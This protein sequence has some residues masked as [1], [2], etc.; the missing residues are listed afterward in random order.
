MGSAIFSALLAV[1]ALSNAA[2]H[3]RNNNGEVLL[4]CGPKEGGRSLF[5]LRETEARSTGMCG[6]S[7]KDLLVSHGPV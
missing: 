1:L 7:T 5:A 6:S 3:P 4:L 2:S